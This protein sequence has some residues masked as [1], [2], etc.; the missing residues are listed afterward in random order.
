MS[1]HPTDDGRLD[2]VQ[3]RIDDAKASA[4]DLHHRDVL[5][6]SGED[7]EHGA[8]EPTG[9]GTDAGEQPD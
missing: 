1:E 3:D 7:D 2:A 5:G 8:F 9:D 4:A 6:D